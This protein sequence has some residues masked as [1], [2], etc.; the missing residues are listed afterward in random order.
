[1]RERNSKASGPPPNMVKHLIVR[2]C[3]LYA[4]PSNARAANFVR[5]MLRLA[6][7]GPNCG[8]SP[9]NAARRRYVPHLAR[10]ILF[11]FSASGRT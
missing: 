9:I 7:R 3:G 6:P 11:L 2:T 4:R 1:M 5:T 8:S 10:A